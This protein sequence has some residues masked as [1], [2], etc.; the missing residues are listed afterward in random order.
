MLGAGSNQPRLLSC[1]R[2]L[3]QYVLLRC[4]AQYVE[5]T[6][7]LVF[8][9]MEVTDRSQI[10]L[11]FTLNDLWLPSPIITKV[12]DWSTHD[13]GHRDFTHRSIYRQAPHQSTL[14]TISA[15]SFNAQKKN[16]SQVSGCTLLE[17]II[18]PWFLH[19]PDL[20]T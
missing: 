19:H 11:L 9:V 2:N 5:N 4:S 10:V 16:F 20:V 14:F 17:W 12:L 13:L 1:H 6:W 8:R 15:S 7:S 18:N 3:D